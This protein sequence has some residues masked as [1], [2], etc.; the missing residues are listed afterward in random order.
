MT[1]KNKTFPNDIHH[2][3]TQISLEQDI[4]QFQNKL[5]NRIMKSPQKPILNEV[6][7]EENLHGLK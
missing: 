5:F 1:R 2:I 7:I 6:K 4:V 3:Q